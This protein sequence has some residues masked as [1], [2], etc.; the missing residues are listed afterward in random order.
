[1]KVDLCTWTKNGS[2]TL[3]PVLKR[4]DRVI[5]AE[6]VGE[7][8]AVDDSSVDSTVKILKEFNWKVYPNRRGFINGGTTEALSHV[9]SKFFVSVEQDVLLEEPDADRANALQN[10]EYLRRL[11]L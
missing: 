11:G 7:K 9:R 6:E 3:I 10:R 5:P 4:I 8:I 2:K 1:M